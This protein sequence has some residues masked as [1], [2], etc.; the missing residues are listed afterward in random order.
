MTIKQIDSLGRIVIPKVFRNQLGLSVG[1]PIDFRVDDESGNL[2]LQKKQD[3]CMR[4]HCTQ[5]LI[6]IKD[7]L[8]L[9]SHCLQEIRKKT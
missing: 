8:Y 7:N 2:I 5:E 9:C 3:I 6:K 4:C 1:T